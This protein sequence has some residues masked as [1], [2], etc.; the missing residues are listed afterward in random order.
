MQGMGKEDGCLLCVVTSFQE[1]MV[2][3]VESVVLVQR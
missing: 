1:S 3:T 2:T